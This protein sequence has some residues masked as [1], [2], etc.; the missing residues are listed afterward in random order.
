MDEDE[1]LARARQLR[2]RAYAPYSGFQV[3]AALAAED[4]RVFDGC[5]VENASYGATIC[6][7]RAALVAAVAAGARRF[8]LLAIAASSAAAVAPCGLCRQ[9]LVEFAP[10]LA[11]V[12]VG[13]DGSVRRWPL[14]ALLPD[15]FDLPSAID[16]S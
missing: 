7:E 4:G 10:D 13:D 12:S 16:G 11:V 5:N 1:L 15:A 3:G 9:A 2:G 6:A 8:V 14:R